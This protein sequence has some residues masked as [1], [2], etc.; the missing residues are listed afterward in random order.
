MKKDDV[1]FFGLMI[2]GFVAIF[3]QGSGHW[4][5]ILWLTICI[6]IGYFM[7][8]F[9][10]LI[11][12]GKYPEGMKFPQEMDFMWMGLG[13]T[14][15]AMGRGPINSFEILAMTAVYYFTVQFINKHTREGF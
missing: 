3:H 2:A 10:R 9:S 14:I 8:P 7:I 12:T 5:T 11:S 4:A 15:A 1:I 13:F 6:H